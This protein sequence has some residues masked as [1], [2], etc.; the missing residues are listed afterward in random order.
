MY[1]TGKKFSVEISE[2][3]CMYYQFS[4][5]DFARI[6]DRA[7]EFVEKSIAFSASIYDTEDLVEIIRWD[8]YREEIVYILSYYGKLKGYRIAVPSVEE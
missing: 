3:G 8:E 4:D 1:E 2:G 7:E 6:E 5:D